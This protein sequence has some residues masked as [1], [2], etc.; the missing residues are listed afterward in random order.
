MMKRV[1]FLM[2][3]FMILIS[4][5]IF[6]GC[7]QKAQKENVLA[8][9]DKQVVTLEELEKE[10]SELPEWKQKKYKDQAGREEYLTLMAESRMLLQV[11]N[12]KGL[13][14]DPEIVKQTREYRDQL[15]V[16]ELVKKEVDDKVRV[17]DDLVSK[18]Y[19]D[20]KD[21]Y[22]EPE[23][24]SVTEV[25]LEDEDK[26]KEVMEKVKGGAD[27]TA[28]AKEMSD[29]AESVGPGQRSE[30]KVTFSQD[31]Y[32]SAREFVETAFGLQAGDISNIIVQPIGEKTYYMIVRLDER[33]P[34]RQKEL[35]EVE[36]KIRR[37]VEK[38][39]KK[40]IMDRWLETIKMEK[41]FQL[42]PDRLPVAVEEE[43]AE[44]EE[45]KP[46]NAAGTEDKAESSDESVEE[47][48]PDEKAKESPSDE[49]T[50]KEQPDE[51]VKE[52]PS[53]EG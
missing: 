16:K 29:K 21:E 30:G 26:A 43:K 14:K 36:S 39:E 33:M 15:V 32:S 7:S 19:A 13:N 53:N 25:T 47:E 28:L 46:E 9:F 3:A 23:K 24:V 51:K 12:E 35:S 38:E 37:E 8:E 41:D 5:C 2:S 44:P 50:E 17:T 22:V 10:I 49:T 18:Y 6:V 20:H 42:Y 11:A 4:S 1:I 48:K 52:T 31:S 34:S 27:F 45:V 40:K